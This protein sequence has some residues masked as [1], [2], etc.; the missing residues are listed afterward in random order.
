MSQ[1]KTTN[2]ALCLAEWKLISQKSLSCHLPMEDGTPGRA[3]IGSDAEGEQ[4]EGPR[5][6]PVP[7]QRVAAALHEPHRR[8]PSTFSVH[9]NGTSACETTV[10]AGSGK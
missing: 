4:E 6:E 3:G 1:M 10:P 9:P 7:A 8:V 2:F 5:R